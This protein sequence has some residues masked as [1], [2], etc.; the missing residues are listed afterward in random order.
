MPLPS[1]KLLGYF[2]SVPVGTV[3]APL[4]PFTQHRL[5]PSLRLQDNDTQIA[6]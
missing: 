2:Q 6:F 3:P 4:V 5:L 1:N